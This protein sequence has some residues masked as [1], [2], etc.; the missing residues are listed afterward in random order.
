MTVFMTKINSIADVLSNDLC[1]GCGACLINSSHKMELNPAGFYRPIS[2][3]ID[4]SPS[5]CPFTDSAINEDDLSNEFLAAPSLVFGLGRY[6]SICCGHVQ[7][8]DIRKASTS[9]GVGTWLPLQLYKLGFV[10]RVIH[11]IPT[12]SSEH[13]YFKYAISSSQDQIL[14]ASGSRYYPINLREVIQEVLDGDDLS[15]CFV[16]LPC[17][18]KTLRL[19]QLEYPILRQRIKFTVAIVCGHMK[20]SLWTEMLAWYA[21]VSPGN[22]KEFRHR[23]KLEDPSFEIRK[24]LFF[25]KSVSGGQRVLDSADVPGG[26]FNSGAFMANACNYCDDVV[27]ETADISLG[28]AWLPRY[29]TDKLGNS[30]IVC[31]NK[32]LDQILQDGQASGEL[33]LSQ[34]T[35]KDALWAQ[36]GGFRQRGEGLAY[37][38]S[39]RVRKQLDCPTKRVQP[40][41]RIP[42]IRKLIYLLRM[43]ISRVSLEYYLIA[44]ARNNLSFYTDRMSIECTIL[45]ILEVLSSLPRV[46]AR[47]IGWL[48]R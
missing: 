11:V 20:S 4:A 22:I 3:R 32:L 39:L 29:E 7:N 9:G 16:G 18:V 13:P 36:A 25:V 47:R 40:S 43:R 30:L 45:R 14:Q 41:Y 21:G 27:G 5:T 19:L 26:K 33:L 31:R 46:V 15:Y 42:F 37:R 12:H 35:P 2:D 28:D 10:D 1:I 38:L 8:I 17:F 34:C 23:S 6:Y 44:K 24:Y 48:F